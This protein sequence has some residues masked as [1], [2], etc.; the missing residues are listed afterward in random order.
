MAIPEFVLRKL[1]VPGSLKENAQGFEFVLLDTFAPATI[2]AFALHVGDQKI[3][4]EEITVAPEN[5]AA[6]P[7]S[8]IDKD[9]PLLASIGISIRITV[10]GHSLSGPVKIEAETR[11]VGLLE[12]TLADSVKKKKYQN[13]K[14]AWMSLFQKPVVSKIKINVDT[15]QGEVSPFLLGQ[16]VEHLERCV[17]DGIWTKDGSALRQDTVELLTKLQI[18]MIRYPGGNF[19]SGYHWEDGIGP[20]EKRPARHDAAWQA[21]ESNRIGTDEFLAFCEEM[22]IEPYLV[23]NDG[24]GSAEEAA[25]WVA[26]CNSAADSEQGKRRAENGHPEPYAVKYWGVGNEVWGPWQIGTTSAKEYAERLHRFVKAMKAVDP[27][28]KIIA[29]GN[30]P[31][32]DRE[33]DPASQWNREVLADCADD[34]DFLSWH[35]YQPEQESWREN[36][37]PAQLFASVVAAPIDFQWIIDRVDAQIQ[38]SKGKGRITQCIDEW[39]IWLPPGENAKS[40]HQVTYTM[41]DA[42]YVAGIIN[43]LYRSFKKVDIANLAQLVNVLPLVKTNEK[44]A[45][46][47][48]IY[49][50]FQLA[51]E[52]EENVLSFEYESET[53]AAPK[54]GENVQA[55]ENVPYLD[56]CVTASEEGD[57]IAML[58]VNRHP[59]KRNQVHVDFSQ[60]ENFQAVEWQELKAN[61][62]LDANTFEHP[63]RVHLHSSNFI[64]KTGNDLVVD[65]A[66]ASVNL[67]KFRKES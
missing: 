40:M 61:H 24:S 52:L 5:A 20:K 36:Y 41:R 50:P 13:L 38:S 67:L 51:A 47:T 35:I 16:F 46:A 9:S 28:I 23:V 21:E 30:N 60:K 12:F 66:P 37:D 49:Y 8:Q 64:M 65:L 58:L 32:T 54:L 6:Y 42:L 15:P 11:E 2:T 26:Y 59:E 25:R 62:P 1:I 27:T 53:F 55:H 18:P 39:N 3:T 34:F 45:I 63:N 19:A 22:D 48:A 4:P 10:A 56:A 7:A 57:A 43:A 31:L 33:N 17:Y 44:T 14:P 29:V